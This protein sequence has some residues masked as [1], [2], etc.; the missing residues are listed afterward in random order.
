VN[1]IFLQH[2]TRSGSSPSPG[3]RRTGFTKPL[4]FKNKEESIRLAEFATAPV[5]HAGERQPGIRSTYKRNPAYWGKIEG[6]VQEIVFTPI[7]NDATRLAALV[8]RRGR[9]HPS[10]PRRATCRACARPPASKVVDGPEN[11][12]VFIGMDQG[13]DELLYSNVKG[14]NP[15]KDVR[16]RKALYQAID[17][18]TLKTKL[19]NGRASRPAA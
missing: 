1:P 7:A 4:D 12:I 18:E 16:V 5:L 13:R 3:A 14:R 8:L 19:M 11:R 9:F 15:F 6:N 17:I 2:L 10:I